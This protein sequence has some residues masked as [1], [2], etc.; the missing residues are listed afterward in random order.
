MGVGLALVATPYRTFEK[1]HAGK[2]QPYTQ[3]GPSNPG[4]QEAA[5]SAEGETS[6]TISA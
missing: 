6:T 2:R 3:M 5:E 4:S 1:R